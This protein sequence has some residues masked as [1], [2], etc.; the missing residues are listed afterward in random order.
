[1]G[2]L[3]VEAGFARSYIFDAFGQSEYLMMVIEGMKTVGDSVVCVPATGQAQSPNGTVRKHPRYHLPTR[4]LIELLAPD[5]LAR[6]TIAGLALKMQILNPKYVTNKQLR[7]VQAQRVQTVARLVASLAQRPVWV[8][9]Q[10]SDG[11]NY[12][13]IN[14]VIQP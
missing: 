6:R 7:D 11:H 10:E 1:M 3:A 9:F 13:Y 5:T 8:R 12:N 14:E 2:E 4:E